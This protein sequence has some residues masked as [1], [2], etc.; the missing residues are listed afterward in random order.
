MAL[1]LVFIAMKTA[2]TEGEKKTLRETHLFSYFPLSFSL[3][4]DWKENVS[5]ELTD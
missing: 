3:Q 2:V 5:E 1:G 4:K